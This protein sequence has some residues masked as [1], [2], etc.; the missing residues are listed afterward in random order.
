MSG[1]FAVHRGVFD[2]PIFKAEPYTEVQAWVWLLGAA[3]WQAGRV[4]VG[5]GVFDLERGQLAAANRFLAAK[6]QWSESK[7]RRFL[8]RLETDAMIESKP[9]RDATLI[10]ICNYDEY[11][12]DRSADRRETDAQPTH[13]RRKEEELNNSKNDDDEDDARAPLVSAKANEIADAVAVICGHDLD[14]I[15]PAWMG[16]AYRVQ[17]WITQGW[18]EAVILASCREQIAKKRDGPPDRIQY[19]EKGIASALAKASAPLPEVKPLPAQTVE[20][21]RGQPE[22]L[23][24]TARRLAG[25]GIS[26]GP[27]PSL[28]PRAE[29]GGSVVRMLPQSGRERS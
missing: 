20:I 9:T 29:S 24:A 11:Q 12:P 25:E 17:T 8:Q 13:K 7:V 28:H 21:R 2:H 19:F 5:K 15:P 3:A 14:F 18:P 6:W 4:R 16:A 27:K 1:Y 26:F 10:T 22:N 23:A